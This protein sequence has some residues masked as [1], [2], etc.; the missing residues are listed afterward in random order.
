MAKVA[1]TA[2]RAR[3]NIRAALKRCIFVFY[4]QK[5]AIFLQVASVENNLRIW[6]LWCDITY[7]S[8][9]MNMSIIELLLFSPWSKSNFL[10]FSDIWL[11][12]I[13]QYAETRW[14]WNQNFATK[15]Q[16]TEMLHAIMKLRYAIMHKPYHNSKQG[17]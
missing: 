6:M 11:V 4:I 13:S 2:T 5:K 8:V 10:S 16:Y 9:T 14:V 1:E 15:I 12:N 7:V 3:V 17:Q